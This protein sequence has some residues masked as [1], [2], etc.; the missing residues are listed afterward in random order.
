MALWVVSV[1]CMLVMLSLACVTSYHECSV[2]CLACTSDGSCVSCL[3]GYYG[4]NCTPCNPDCNNS[5]C[6]FDLCAEGCV[7]GLYGYTC[8]KDC[9]QCQHGCDQW[10]GICLDPYTPT[11]QYY[12]AGKEHIPLHTSYKI[13]IGIMSIAGVGILCTICVFVKEKRF[14]YTT[15]HTV[16]RRPRQRPL[17]MRRIPRN[18]STRETFIW[19]TAPDN[20]TVLS[21]ENITSCG[22]ATQSLTSSNHISSTLKSEIIP[23]NT[24]QTVRILISPPS[25]CK[26]CV[27]ERADFPPTYVSLFP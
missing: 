12:L 20:I 10:K 21:T 2:N 13:M 27:A 18:N 4:V 16:F 7:K 15:F 6:L 11:T 17:R 26:S 3:A 1:L 22:I 14:R 9:R 5:A 8:D 23:T 24:K 25:P 19:E